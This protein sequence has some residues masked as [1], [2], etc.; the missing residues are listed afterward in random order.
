MIFGTGST[1]VVRSHSRLTFNRTVIL[2]HGVVHDIARTLHSTAVLECAVVLRDGIVQ[3]IARIWI[4]GRAW[5][6]CTCI[7]YVD[8]DV[9]QMVGDNFNMCAVSICVGHEVEVVTH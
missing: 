7:C 8:V 4:G 2:R 5:I 9:E 3:D 1:T 6:G